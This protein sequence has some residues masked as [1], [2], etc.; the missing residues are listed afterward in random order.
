MNK[1]ESKKIQSIIIQLDKTAGM[2]T[3]DA[4]KNQAIREAVDKILDASFELG[5]LCDG[6]LNEL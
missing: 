6:N 1:K 3:V 5:I 2:L 4:S